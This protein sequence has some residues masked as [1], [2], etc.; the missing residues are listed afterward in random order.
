[1]DAADW[2]RRYEGADYVWE[3][4]PNRFVAAHVLP[5]VP[6]RALDL[7]AGEGRN[8]VWLAGRGWAATAVDFSAAGLAKGE[9]LAA[10]HGVAIATEVADV[11]TYD[12]SEGA[13]DLVL[14]SYLQLPTAERLDVVARAARGVAPGG[15]L[16]VVA[17]D[18]SNLERGHGGPQDPDV[19]YEVDETLAALDGTPLTPAVAT[20][21]GRSVVKDD[22]EHVALDTLVVAQ[23]R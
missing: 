7:G 17:H 3:I 18:R 20:V 13:W 23:R 16:L 14:L 15:T 6:G 12:V 8:A 11:R 19:L 10:D 22:G 4:E 21:V 9:R 5:L 1:M 2:D